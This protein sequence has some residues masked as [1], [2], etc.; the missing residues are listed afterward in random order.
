MEQFST[1]V[2]ER[3][4]PQ[5]I[6]SNTV[7]APPTNDSNESMMAGLRQEKR[8]RE[9]EAKG[10][11]RKQRRMVVE[12]SRKKVTVQ[13]EKKE[14]KKQQR[15]HG[16]GHEVLDAIQQS[17]PGPRAKEIKVVKLDLQ[18][19]WHRSRQRRSGVDKSEILGPTSKL[20]G[21]EAKLQLLVNM[22]KAWNIDRGDDGAY[23]SEP[24]DSESEE[25]LDDDDLEEADDIG[26]R[27]H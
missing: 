8:Q 20:G 4:I 12:A 23:L 2:L 11:Q 1:D 24:E 15:T 10:N 5:G 3:Q 26:Y 9:E 17:P 25:L 14:R 27:G 6:D 16:Y 13:Q 18:L 21:K 19:D 22:V 7:Y